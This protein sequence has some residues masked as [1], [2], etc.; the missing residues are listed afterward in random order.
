MPNKRIVC[1]NKYA[2]SKRVWGGIMVI[3]SITIL[4]ACSAG[5][6]R[7]WQPAPADGGDPSSEI[8]L[9]EISL[10][11]I[12]KEA[13]ALFSNNCAAC[14]GPRGGG[15]RFAPP[16][17]SADLRARLDDAALA[18]T[19]TNGRP[20][21]AMPAWGGRLTSEEITTLVALIRRW[22]FLEEEQLG[23]LEQQAS[24]VG[25]SPFTQPG[26]MGHGPMHGPMMGGGNGMR[27]GAPWR[28]PLQP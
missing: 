1:T 20:G 7:P 22:H 11:G 15:S 3:F 16:L 28:D 2:V 13:F 14:H 4:A 21:T 17:N 10:P 8:S 26:M 25:G 18:D 19:I 12:P 9:S 23:Q 24:Q 5:I 6:D 27:W